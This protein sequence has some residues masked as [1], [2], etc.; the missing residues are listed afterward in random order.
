MKENG[1]MRPIETVLRIG[2]GRVYYNYFV[3]VTMYPSKTVIC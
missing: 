3:N 1:T 2:G